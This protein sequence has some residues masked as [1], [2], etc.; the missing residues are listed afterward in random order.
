MLNCIY[1]LLLCVVIQAAVLRIWFDSYLFQPVQE[2]LESKREIGGWRGFLIKL[3]T[4][5]QCFGT[6]VGFVVAFGLAWFLPGAPFSPANVPCIFMFGVSTGMLS[7]LLDLF[8]L[9]KLR[10]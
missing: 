9:S 6:W 3:A 7:E 8:V 10:S 4:C 1:F 2:Y 5:Y